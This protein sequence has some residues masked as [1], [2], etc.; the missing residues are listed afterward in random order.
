[1]AC[2]QRDVGGID[3]ASKTSVE[4]MESHIQFTII[5]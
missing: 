5:H 2:V 4:G 3:D 1:M